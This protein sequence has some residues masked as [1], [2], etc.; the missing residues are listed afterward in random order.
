MRDERT[1]RG[2]R[3]MRTY[4]LVITI[5]GVVLLAATLVIGGL[6]GAGAADRRRHRRGELGD[7]RAAAVGV[8]FLRTR[9]ERVFYTAP[10]VESAGAAWR[11]G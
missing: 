4:Q 5:L 11:G 8:R 6:S 10:I 7:L 1:P 9:D 3:G 2:Q